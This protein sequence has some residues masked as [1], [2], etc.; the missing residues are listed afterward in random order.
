MFLEDAGLYA[1]FFLSPTVQII[2]TQIY[3]TLIL[4]RPKYG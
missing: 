3:S 2:L 1:E 4:W